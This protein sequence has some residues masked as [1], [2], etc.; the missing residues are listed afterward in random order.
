MKVD[1][2][3]LYAIM[4]TCKASLSLV[5]LAVDT[6][7]GTSLVHGTQTQ[8][9]IADKA[10]ERSAQVEDILGRGTWSVIYNFGLNNFMYKHVE[11]VHP[12]KVLESDRITLMA[13]DDRYAIF[14]VCD[15]YDVYD[16]KT[17]PFVFLMQFLQSNRLIIM[18][19]ESL[20]R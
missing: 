11:Y 16:P 17:H 5:D 19:T 3:I 14:S 12:K 2:A 8:R 20:H 9:K 7:T 1:P 4:K 18:P 15:E 13:V 6:L 10:Y